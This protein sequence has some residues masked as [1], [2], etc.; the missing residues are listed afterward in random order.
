[1]NDQTTAAASGRPLAP[2]VTQQADQWFSLFLSRQDTPQEREQWRAWRAA[3]PEHER[4][5]QRVESIHLHIERAPP[6]TRPTAVPLR[7]SR[8]GLLTAVVIVTL[9]AGA[10]AWTQ[11]ATRAAIERVVHEVRN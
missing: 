9:A 11:P 7:R 2:A 6:V 1:M 8:A 4:A 5:W 3:D 10:L